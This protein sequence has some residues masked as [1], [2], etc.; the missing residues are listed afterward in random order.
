MGRR[1]RVGRA[2]VT[3]K[4]LGRWCGRKEFDAVWRRQRAGQSRS[5]LVQYVSGVSYVAS[6]EAGV[7]RTG[8]LC[9]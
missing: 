6:A 2:G 3:S 5:A 1:W 7:A 9:S 4:G 8:S